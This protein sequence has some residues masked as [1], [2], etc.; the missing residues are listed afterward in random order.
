M[1]R[2]WRSI[3]VVVVFFM[4]SIGSC[5]TVLTPGGTEGAVHSHLLLAFVLNLK[6]AYMASLSAH[7]LIGKNHDRIIISMHNCVIEN[8]VIL[9]N[10]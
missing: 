1:L 9:Q 4:P 5:P 6:W 3:M 7:S 2:F 8:G 10:I